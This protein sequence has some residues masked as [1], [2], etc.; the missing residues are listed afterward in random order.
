MISIPVGRYVLDTLTYISACIDVS[1]MKNIEFVGEGIDI[2]NLMINGGV[3]NKCLFY[4]SQSENISWR[5]MTLDGNIGSASN[6][7]GVWTD[8]TGTKQLLFD[9]VK[10][11]A[12]GNNGIHIQNV[13]IAVVRNSIFEYC[14]NSGL[15]FSCSDALSTKSII[16]ENNQFI[17]NEYE[18]ILLDT[19]QSNGNNSFIKDVII[20]KNSLV[21]G[22]PQSPAM[23][24]KAR[25]SDYGV[26]DNMQITGNT[27]GST[28][29]YFENCINLNFSNN[30]LYGDSSTSN[31]QPSPFFATK[32]IEKLNI[33]NNIIIQSNTNTDGA[34]C[35][36]SYD[37]DENNK[38]FNAKYVNIVGNSIINGRCS[39]ENVS[40]LSFKSNIIQRNNQ[41][42]DYGF[43]M[44]I[45]RDS[46]IY[47]ITDYGNL[48]IAG[49]QIN[50]VT[51][52]GI[53]IS[54]TDSSFIFNTVSID[55]NTFNGSHLENGIM[56]LPI[57]P[58]TGI[59]WKKALI[60]PSNTIGLLASSSDKGNIEVEGSYETAINPSEERW[61]SDGDPNEIIEAPQGSLSI[62]K[63][64]EADNNYIKDKLEGNNGWEL[65]SETGKQIVVK[66]V[67]YNNISSPIP[68]SGACLTDIGSEGDIP[69]IYVFSTGSTCPWY[70]ANDGGTNIGSW[71]V[72]EN[73]KAYADVLYSGTSIQVMNTAIALVN[74]I[75]NPIYKVEIKSVFKVDTDLIVS[76][77]KDTYVGIVFWYGDYENFWRWYFKYDYSGGGDYYVILERIYAGSIGYTN[78]KKVILGSSEKFVI[79]VML[80]GDYITVFYND[81]LMM[82]VLNTDKH[83]NTHGLIMFEDGVSTADQLFFCESFKQIIP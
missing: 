13:E 32:K 15:K 23:S 33:E 28:N 49:N 73:H 3:N 63:T 38:H 25:N 81:L 17:W 41:D 40:G 45:S 30:F 66:T 44:K 35:I 18:D 39:F 48:T 60:A 68:P 36:K 70:L 7:E 26:V 72:S 6:N 53:D 69:E 20:T 61:I 29:V 75:D 59:F 22:T 37:D 8:V 16:V 47:G 55:V 2:S 65:T 19:S 14:Y 31:Y 24:V 11:I 9:E 76:I 10:I 74:T 12:F 54:T 27:F 34:L 67:F 42:N 82:S 43:I 51:K 1:G 62:D 80:H 56:I 83:Y 50:N 5:K 52:N 57:Y 71:K 58:A 4:A 64:I 79:K 78:S 46:N 77:G 21:R